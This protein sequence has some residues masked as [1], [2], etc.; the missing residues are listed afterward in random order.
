VTLKNLTIIGGSGFVGKSIVD[1][2]NNGTIEKFK[3]KKINII[4]RK[5]SKIKK[6]K[7]L[8]LNKINIIQGNICKIKKLPKS[9]VVIYAAE[10]SNTQNYKNNKNFVGN[11]K[12][13][14]KN[15]CK[16]IK[17]MKRIK[18]LYVSSGA[19]YRNK[20]SNSDL[21]KFKHTYSDLKIYTENQIRKLGNFK[22]KTSIARCFSFVGPRLLDYD[23]YAIG[24]FI[25]DGL[26]KKFIKVKAKQ[27]VVRS[28]MYSDDL[29]YW[30]IKIADKSN[31][32]CPV[33]NVGSDQPV[34]LGELAKII[35][36]IFDK[37]VLIKRKNKKVDKYVPNI[38]KAKKNLNLRINFNLMQSIYYTIGN[39][40]NEKI[41]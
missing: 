13:A 33:Y 16:I 39:Y 7:S 23:H 32:K 30:L 34:E 9:D 40:L 31:I 18:V 29:A 28:Y 25:N 21:K 26:N 37:P 3:I 6:I 4:C 17:K 15:F 41:I 35:G 1:S 5:P 38:G 27:Y 12:K 19:V 8:G 14:V 20:I 11:H 22:I 36:K 10:S 24:S 2:F